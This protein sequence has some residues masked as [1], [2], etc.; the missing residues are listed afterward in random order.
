MKMPKKINKIC[1]NCK[2]LRSKHED[3]SATGEYAEN[4]VCPIKDLD[5]QGRYRKLSWFE[6]MNNLEYLEWKATGEI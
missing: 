6:P 2:K 1:K 4:V 3:W 5:K